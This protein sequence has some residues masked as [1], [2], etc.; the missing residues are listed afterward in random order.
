MEAHASCF[1][2]A[3]MSSS[4]PG[5]D[6]DPDHPFPLG[7]RTVLNNSAPV[8]HEDANARFYLAVAAGEG[9][10]A[11]GCYAAAAVLRDPR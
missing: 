3:M 9:R 11:P 8:N 7:K 10:G 2:L 1:S 6:S 5:Q 4:T